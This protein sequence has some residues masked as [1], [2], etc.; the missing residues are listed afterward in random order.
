[1]AIS[2]NKYVDSSTTFPSATT[3]GRAF[4]GLVITG[5]KNIQ[6]QIPVDADGNPIPPGSD[7]PVANATMVCIYNS[8]IAG[9]AEQVSLNDIGIL[10]TVNSP[11]YKLAERYYS[12]ISPSGR[13]ASKL[14]VAL[15]RPAGHEEETPLEAFNRVR[16]ET[17]MFGSFTFTSLNGG[18]DSS[19]E[20]VAD[21]LE[22]LR[23]VAK[24][25]GTDDTLDTRFLFIVNDVRS[26]QAAEV[27]VQKVVGDG[28]VFDAV[29]GTCFISGYD[30]ASACMPMAILASTDYD[31]GTVVNYMFKQFD[32][33]TPTVKDDATYQKFNKANINFY[34]RTQSNGQTIDFYQRGFNSDGTDTAVYCNEMWFK[35]QCDTALM[36]LLLSSERISSDNYGVDMVRSTVLEQC[37]KGIGNG[38]F[39]PKSVDPVEL[40]N[41][42]LLIA[43]I[44]GTNDDVDNI[45]AGINSVGYS[46]Y[47]YLAYVSPENDTKGQLGSSGEYIIH[48]YV[49]YGTADSIRHIKGDDILIK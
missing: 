4:G 3:V 34:G 9:A 11:E 10:F 38:M 16:G 49:F 31:D 8:L 29:K 21:G 15:F 37:S 19:D 41:L 25:N 5:N 23:K 26:S 13:V 44:G 33:E 7:T 12:F 6:P 17:N 24:A 45:V 48:Y 20:T 43:N 14:T 42:R 46:V 28:T 39:M 18:G 36:A 2:I 1:M 40:R 32:G 35:S 22:E 47:A 27:V 30:E